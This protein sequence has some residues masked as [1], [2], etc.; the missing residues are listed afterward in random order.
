MY[1]WPYPVFEAVG[2]EYHEIQRD[3]DTA[4][5]AVIQIQLDTARYIRIQLDT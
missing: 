2:Y 1:F 3:T 4:D 5:T